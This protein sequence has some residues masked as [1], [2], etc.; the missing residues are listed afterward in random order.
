MLTDQEL[1]NKLSQ[2]KE[3]GDE[4]LAQELYQDCQEKLQSGQPSPRIAH[5]VQDEVEE[6]MDQPS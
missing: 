5:I 4:E 1:L 3:T 6:Y 2:V